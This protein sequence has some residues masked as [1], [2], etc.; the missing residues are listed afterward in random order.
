[1]NQTKLASVVTADGG[2]QRTMEGS[3]G[4]AGTASR[5]QQTRA[6]SWTGSQGESRAARAEVW[7]Q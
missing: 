7:A 2:K 4:A 3:R 6:D 1:M 5:L